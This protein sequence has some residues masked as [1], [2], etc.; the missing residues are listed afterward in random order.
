MELWAKRAFQM[1]IEIDGKQMLMDDADSHL[2]DG[3]RLSL[4]KSRNTYYAVFGK[5][6]AV[7][8]LV[9][10]VNDPQLIVD[11]LNGDGLDNRR[12]NLRIVTRADNNRNRQ[13][14]RNKIKGLPP[15]IHEYRGKYRVQLTHEYKKICFGVYSDIKD[16]IAKLQEARANLG[17]PKLTES[18]PATHN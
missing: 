13:V 2:V 6:G 8:R 10:N 18:A 15:G 11:H 3:I 7:H 17:R 16:A 12:S 9:C 4:R 14:S 5:K 1:I